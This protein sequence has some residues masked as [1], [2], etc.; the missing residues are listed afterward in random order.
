MTSTQTLL[1]ATVRTVIPRYS[2]GSSP[3]SQGPSDL[4]TALSN[5]SP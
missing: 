5:T 2:E 4:T 3:E 1:A